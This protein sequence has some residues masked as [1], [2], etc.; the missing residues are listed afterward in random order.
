MLPTELRQRA[1][2][3]KVRVADGAEITASLSKQSVLV[4]EGG[5]L[6][7]ELSVPHSAKY[8]IWYAY[9]LA[10]SYGRPILLID[11]KP[12][13]A[14]L[15]AHRA[16]LWAKRVTKPLALAEGEH[17]ITLKQ[18]SKRAGLF[19]LCFEPLFRDLG[20]EHFAA[21]GPLPGIGNV[22]KTDLVYQRLDGVLPLENPVDLSAA[23]ADVG[24]K[25][26]RWATPVLGASLTGPFG[27][28]YVDLY[29]TFGVMSNVVC[30]AV[31]RIDS[32]EEREALISFG[33]DYWAKVTLNRE[34]AFR[35]ED[36][37]RAAP[38]KGE[39]TFPVT[40]RKGENV[41]FIK[42]HA[43]SAG[44]GFWLSITDPG[45]LEISSGMPRGPAK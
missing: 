14:P 32:P 33:A 9:P 41:L 1:S 24:G 29:K 28:G 8:R 23:Y 16:S 43:G 39:V 40:L 17:R 37:P 12:E 34:E 38:A 7:L 27:K 15:P 31:T 18:T 4:W 6:E 19:Y 44:N 42:N 20:P 3:E 22:R 35:P 45:D 25:E 26:V 30:C 36:R 10:Q 13:K 21:I 5:S 2:A 11:G